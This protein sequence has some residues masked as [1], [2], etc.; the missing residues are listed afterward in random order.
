MIHILLNIK[1][2]EIVFICMMYGLPVYLYI[3]AVDIFLCLKMLN[4]VFANSIF[5]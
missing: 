1:T 5:K 2:V 3:K 4:C